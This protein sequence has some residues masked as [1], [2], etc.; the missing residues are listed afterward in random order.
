PVDSNNG[1]QIKQVND[2]SSNENILD[3]EPKLKDLHRLFDSSA[4]H[5]STIGTALD[6]E[7]DNLL[8]SPLSA[9]DKLRTVFKR[10]IESNKEVTWRNALQV[11]EDY[12]D[13]RGVTVELLLG[14]KWLPVVRV[15]VLKV[16]QFLPFSSSLDPGYWQEL[17]KRKLE[18]YQLREDPVPIR[19]S[20]GNYRNISTPFLSLD[21]TAFDV[22]YQPTGL[23]FPSLGLLR[24]MNTI[25]SFNNIDK[26]ELLDTCGRLILESIKNGNCLKNSSLLMSFLLFTYADLKKYRFNYWFGFPALSPSSPFTYRSISRLDTL[27]KDSDLQHLVSCYDHFQSEHKSVGF[28]LVNCS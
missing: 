11:C 16:L 23:D 12:P 17:G 19:G 26:K 9:S 1:T 5:Y 6:V 22:G 13:K 18:E 3:K 7:V 2:Q 21:Y 14:R 10:W 20:N 27:F 25:A 15:K 8:H 4:A 28:F 24:N